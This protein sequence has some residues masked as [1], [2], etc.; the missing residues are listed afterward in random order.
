MSKLLE[1]LNRINTSVWYGERHKWNC[2]CRR[3]EFVVLDKADGRKIHD[4][5]I[6]YCFCCGAKLR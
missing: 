5:Y 6:E 3:K 2:P 1:W 4:S